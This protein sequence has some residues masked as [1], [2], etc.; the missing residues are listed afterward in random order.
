MKETGTL[1]KGKE[2]TNKGMLYCVCYNSGKR[3][4]QKKPNPCKSLYP[5][6]YWDMFM[7]RYQLSA[8]I[9]MKWKC[10]YLFFKFIYLFLER[11]RESQADSA[12]S[13]QNP[14]RGSILQTVIMTWAKIKSTKL[15]RLRHPGALNM[16]IF[17]WCLLSR[18]IPRYFINY[19]FE[20]ALCNVPDV[21]HTPNPVPNGQSLLTPTIP[22]KILIF[23]PGHSFLSLKKKS[24]IYQKSTINTI[25]LLAYTAFL[26]PTSLP[27]LTWK[28]NSI[29]FKTKSNCI[30]K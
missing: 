6:D 11:E 3:K 25:Y 16:F 26:L 19:K 4:W 18:E 9:Y 27:P 29:R 28:V 24:S 8:I 2:P 30:G 17:I 14:M 5:L 20:K 13:G 23:L 10:S 15:N 12:L 7:L 22:L 1:E 21:V